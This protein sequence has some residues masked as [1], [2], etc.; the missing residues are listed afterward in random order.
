M[1]PG[2]SYEDGEGVGWPTLAFVLVVLLLA[3]F[4]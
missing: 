2:P 1:N 3:I 4:L